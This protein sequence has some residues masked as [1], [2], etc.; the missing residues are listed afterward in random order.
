MGDESEA[1]MERGKKQRMDGRWEVVIVGSSWVS[2]CRN[3]KDSSAAEMV[4]GAVVQWLSA[5]SVARWL[6]A[7]WLLAEF[8]VHSGVG[9]LGVER[10][11]SLLS[12]RKLEGRTTKYLHH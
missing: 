3:R 12:G 9:I 5:R 1:A 7:G 10:L 6:L 4:D 2:C 11:H 8:A